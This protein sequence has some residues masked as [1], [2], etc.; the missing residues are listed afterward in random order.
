MTTTLYEP[1]DDT[2]NL[3]VTECLLQ[4]FFD[5]LFYFFCLAIWSR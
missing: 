2:V 5:F 3:L 4:A 1:K